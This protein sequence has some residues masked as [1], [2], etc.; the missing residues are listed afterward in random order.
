MTASLSCAKQ[1]WRYP[2][3]RV[4]GD[5]RGL[6]RGVLSSRLGLASSAGEP[7]A[8]VLDPASPADFQSRVSPGGI[9]AWA[10][11][12]LKGSSLHGLPACQH[13][14]IPPGRLPIGQLS[15][16][17]GLRCGSDPHRSP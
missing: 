14:G 4:C 2:Q 13:P 17:Y 12:P 16:G 15:D 1:A 7:K 6:I 3:I 11:K 10:H 9:Q 8:S 5:F